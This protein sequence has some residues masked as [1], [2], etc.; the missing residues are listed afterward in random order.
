MPKSDPV[1]G[2]PDTCASRDL[3][4]L[5]ERHR[6]IRRYRPD[7]VPA[8]L[9]ESILAGA[10][11]GA[12]SS[13]NM[14]AYSV[15][16]TT[17]K[18]RLAEL[19]PLHFHQ[20]MVIEAPVFLTFCAD[21]RR[22]R[23]WLAARE[24]PDNFDNPM[25]FLIGAIDAV[26][27]AQNAALAAEAA[28]LGICFLGTTLAS[29]EGV[30][31]VLKL[32]T[33]VMPVVGFTLGWPAETPLPR[34]RLP[35]ASLVHR[36][37]YADADPLGAYTDREQRGWE[38]YMADPELRNAIERAGVRNLAQVYTAIKYTRESHIG[39]SREVMDCLAG[40]G[41]LDSGFNT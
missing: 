24:A 15:I 28:G 3:R 17:D 4:A 12:S 1:P 22:M 36:E 2:L 19:H 33:G 18:E 16:V 6:S 38:R 39:Y 40:Q 34:D 10:I 29:C 32:P 23:R 5:F 35:L 26:L 13:G 20:D 8:E 25:S 14:Q 37:V 9:V 41:Y 7:P 21:F 31:R 30:A 27:V 11:R